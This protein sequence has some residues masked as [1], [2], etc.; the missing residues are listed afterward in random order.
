M[1][2]ALTSV[3]TRLHGLYH[4]GVHSVDAASH[5]RSWLDCPHC[6]DALALFCSHAHGSI[7][8]CFFAAAHVVVVCESCAVVPACRAC[9]LA[10]RTVVPAVYKR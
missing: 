3:R 8:A 7:A 6:G 5:I 1:V 4:H 9:R 2:Q 10:R